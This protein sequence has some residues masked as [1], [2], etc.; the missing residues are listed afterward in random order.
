MHVVATTNSLFETT[1]KSCSLISGIPTILLIDPC[2]IFA[3]FCHKNGRNWHF[4]GFPFMV[5]DN[6]TLYIYCPRYPLTKPGTSASII[7]AVRVRTVDT[8]ARF[9][10]GNGRLGKQAL[11]VARLE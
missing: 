4:S 9:K 7:C 10:K 11:E 1:D 5:S 3:S 8:N 2:E 6:S